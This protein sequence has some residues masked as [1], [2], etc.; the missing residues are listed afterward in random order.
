MM[1]ACKEASDSETLPNCWM[2][3]GNLPL[4]I[5]VDCLSTIGMYVPLQPETWCDFIV[6][7][8]DIGQEV[9]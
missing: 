9:V 5:C 1:L 8:R 3:K 4:G 6:Y 7:P 2:M